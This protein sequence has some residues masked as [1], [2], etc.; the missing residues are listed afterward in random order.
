MTAEVKSATGA[1][2][3]ITKALDAAKDK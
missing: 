1:L 3:G 2:K